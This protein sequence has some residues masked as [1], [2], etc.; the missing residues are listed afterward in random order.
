MDKWERHYAGAPSIQLE[1]RFTNPGEEMLVVKS[2][3]KLVQQ[4][5]HTIQR[6]LE[7]LKKEETQLKHKEELTLKQV[8]K[9]KYTRQLHQDK[10]EFM[11][12]W[13]EM[14]EKER[15]DLRHKVLEARMNQRDKI[16]ES[17]DNLAN[18]RKVSAKQLRA[19]ELKWDFKHQREQSFTYEVE[20]LSKRSSKAKLIALEFSSFKE[21]R[22]TKEERRRQEMSTHYSHRI[23]SERSL[24]DRMEDKIAE[25]KNLEDRLLEGLGFSPKPKQSAL[26][27]SDI[28]TESHRE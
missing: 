22:R 19:E 25:L 21:Q 26:A 10:S 28:S 16:V 9:R 6:R 15:R 12:M 2:R 4:K 1:G 24:I 23:G 8:G 27:M 17:R 3:R 5:L 11:Q 14:K 13:R 18:K 7:H 20:D